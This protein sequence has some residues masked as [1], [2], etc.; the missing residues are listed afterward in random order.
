MNVNHNSI[1]ILKLNF[2]SLTTEESYIMIMECLQNW[3]PLSSMPLEEKMF[4]TQ[5]SL[6]LKFH[7][8][9]STM[10]GISTYLPT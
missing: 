2:L 7:R 6:P 1:A 4:E 3:R 5:L 10:F 9:M 8:T